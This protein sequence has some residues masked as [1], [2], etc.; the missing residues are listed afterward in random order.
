MGRWVINE[1]GGITAR[2]RVRKGGKGVFEG[3]GIKKRV[4]VSLLRNKWRRRRQGSRHGFEVAV[5]VEI[6]VQVGVDVRAGAGVGA[7]I[8][9]GIV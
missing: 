1:R 6:G 9:I 7:G 4:W 3:A 8:G 2:M 5:G